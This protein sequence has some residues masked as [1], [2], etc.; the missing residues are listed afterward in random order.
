[1]H[2]CMYVCMY[3]GMYV[4]MYS[5]DKGPAANFSFHKTLRPLKVHLKASTGHLACALGT[6][7]IPVL[8]CKILRVSVARPHLVGG[9]S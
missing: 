1:M 6:T 9:T 8:L 7:L 5:T 4:C 2:V 3:V